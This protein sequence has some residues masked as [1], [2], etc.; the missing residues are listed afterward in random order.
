MTSIGPSRELFI[1]LMSFEIAPNLV[2]WPLSRAHVLSMLVLLIL[3]RITMDR[4]LTTSIGS[5][6]ASDDIILAPQSINLRARAIYSIGYK[7]PRRK[8]PGH[9]SALIARSRMLQ[10]NPSRSTI[11]PG[12]LRNFCRHWKSSN[13]NRIGMNNTNPNR[14][15]KGIHFP[16]TF[17][18]QTS[19]L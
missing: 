15:K 2:L 12:K 18:H 16:Q 8:L 5:S 13:V 9:S 1:D 19:S 14:K 11:R 10:E 7:A 6:A 17:N 4:F 3:P